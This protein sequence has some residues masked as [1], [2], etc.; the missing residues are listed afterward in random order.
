MPEMDGI[1]CMKALRDSGNETTIIL[2]GTNLPPESI[3]RCAECGVVDFLGKPL[4]PSRL[5]EAVKR[6][7]GHDESGFTKMLGAARKMDWEGAMPFLPELEPTERAMWEVY[8]E[9]A[10]GKQKPGESEV[11][12][13]G[14]CPLGDFEKEPC[15]ERLANC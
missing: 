8:L 6:V 15:C 2:M 7:L 5:R 1:E 4:E 13:G 14:V 11:C 12:K 10:A 9:L 3:L